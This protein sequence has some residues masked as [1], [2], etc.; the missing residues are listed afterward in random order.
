MLCSN[1]CIIH[2][3]QNFFNQTVKQCIELRGHICKNPLHLKS[4]K[5]TYI[6]ILHKNQSRRDIKDFEDYSS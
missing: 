1:Q 3:E 6:S 2:I 5:L 4:L